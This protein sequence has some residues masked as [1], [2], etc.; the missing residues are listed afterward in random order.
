VGGQPDSANAFPAV[1]RLSIEGGGG[2]TGVLVSSR[3]ILTAAHCFGGGAGAKAFVNV[4]FGPSS[5][6]VV[7]HTYAKSG[8]VALRIPAFAASEATSL[9]RAQDLALFRLDAPVPPSVAR[10]MAIA[11]FRGAAAC[12]ATTTMQTLG[13]SGSQRNVLS[14]GAWQR[15]TAATGETW[16]RWPTA[17]TTEV[18]QGGDSGGP[19]IVAGRICGI[20]SGA[21]M[22]GNPVS[23]T[24]YDNA[25]VDSPGNV[26][27]LTA[28]LVG[29]DNKF[30]N[31]AC[32][33]TDYNGADSDGDGMP[34]RCDNC[35]TPNADQKNSDGDELGDACDNCVNTKNDDQSN[36]NADAE[37]SQGRPALGDM[38]DPYHLAKVQPVLCDGSPFQACG[39]SRLDGSNQRTVNVSLRG[40]P[41]VCAGGMAA[42]DVAD[43]NRIVVDPVKI[44]SVSEDRSYIRVMRCPCT[45]SKAQCDANIALC[46]R[47]DVRTPTG[48]WSAAKLVQ[49]GVVA[50]AA[51]STDGLIPQK[52]YNIDSIIV[53]QSPESER[54]Y[55]W[56]YWTEPGITVPAI[57]SATATTIWQGYHWTWVKSF[58]TTLQ[59]VGTV[60]DPANAVL[61]QSINTMVPVTV[62]ERAPA[63]T[64][65][66][67]NTFKRRY[68]RLPPRPRIV[69]DVLR[70]DV[71]VD[72]EQFGPTDAWREF[73]SDMP[74]AGALRDINATVANEISDDSKVRIVVADDKP[75]VST[76][77]RAAVVQ[78]DT[79][80][81][82]DRLRYDTAGRLVN[83]VPT[84]S[85]TRPK[86][87]GALAV[88]A[89]RQE[90]RAFSREAASGFMEVRA[91]GLDGL[92]DRT[93]LL[94]FKPRNP[95][96]AAYRTLD[97]AYYILDEGPTSMRLLRVNANRQVDVM[98]SWPRSNTTT[99]IERYTLTASEDGSLTLTRAGQLLAG[100]CGVV[101]SPDSTGAFASGRLFANHS[102]VFYGAHL[103]IDNRFAWVLGDANGEKTVESKLLTTGESIPVAGASACF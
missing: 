29:R 43:G 87:L 99:G 22:L 68:L 6:T 88:S 37:T 95:V 65:R 84:A 59:T 69:G 23:A 77:Y 24:D 64:Y 97:D 89:R 96:A 19:N 31:S 44:C 74:P 63:Y 94:D 49:N 35:P 34:N 101:L 91:I 78:I 81:L 33:P 70:G 39:S 42:W 66:V 1:A 82:I 72:V 61:R 62:R 40:I 25:A 18:I 76:G 13:Y 53:N 26:A 102:R 55:A 52:H 92:G 9:K 7:S 16:W 46:G 90:L 103:G 15:Q 54:S 2:C 67:C 45:L 75:L 38:C 58:G 21:Q 5:N 30:V 11:G 14:T 71:F 28:V 41:A 80:D 47:G 73:V 60:S 100:A 10:P 48:L 3:H 20:T 57:P 8:T 4:A 83:V 79:G 17:H 85:T 51:G 98:A 56:A 12:A 50:T 86:A 27:W 36:V 93:E 32:E